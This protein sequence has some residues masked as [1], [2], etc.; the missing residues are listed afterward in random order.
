MTDG[1][2]ISELSKLQT[3]NKQLENH[4]SVY[5]QRL[6]DLIDLVP[7]SELDRLLLRYGVRD[8]CEVP[9]VT[10]NG[11]NNHMANMNGRKTP[12]LGM[13]ILNCNLN[14]CL[15]FD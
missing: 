2:K 7:K 14:A 3:Q 12:D 10:E 9:Q 4:T 15:F 8:I 6:K 1:T 11:I 5:R 13:I